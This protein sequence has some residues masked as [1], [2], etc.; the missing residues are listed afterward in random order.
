MDFYHSSATAE[1]AIV[2]MD[3]L[4][5]ESSCLTDLGNVHVRTTGSLVK[6]LPAL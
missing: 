4:E 6:E 1:T 5:A 3:S 2:K